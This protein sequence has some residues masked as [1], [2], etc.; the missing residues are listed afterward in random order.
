MGKGSKTLKL[1]IMQKERFIAMLFQE[2][3]KVKRTWIM[4]SLI[5]IAIGIV[6]MMCPVR[7]MGMMVSALG[8]VLL[9]WATVLGL[10][11]LA[12]KK[13]LMNYVTL[14]GALFVG[15]LGMFVL[16][17]R[18]D[19][20]PIMGLLF[21]LFLVFEGLSDLFNAFVYARRAGKA[22][23]WFLA[24]LSLITI[25]LGVILLA[26]PWWDTPFVLKRVVGLMML[27]TSAVSIIRVIMT[28]P[29]K[30]V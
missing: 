7:Y 26:N 3:G 12:S 20:L 30:S 15:L 23:W 18:R 13:T 6:M 19:V 1:F 28:W 24:F 29:F 25:S 2:L 4:T 5:L 22:A 21:G 17:H 16:V 9:V 14:T 8:Y 10:N 11:Y 27:F